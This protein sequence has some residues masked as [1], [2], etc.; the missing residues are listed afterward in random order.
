M[1]E[2]IILSV[3]D[4]LAKGMGFELPKT[5]KDARPEIYNSLHV[6]LLSF[7]VYYANLYEKG[8]VVSLKKCVEQWG[9][10]NGGFDTFTEM[11]CSRIVRQV[12]YGQ[13]LSSSAI[14]KK[15]VKLKNGCCVSE[16]EELARRAGKERGKKRALVLE[17][18]IKLATSMKFA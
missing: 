14:P 2:N 8:E 10:V 18:I 15:N 13:V 1:R 6:G 17:E 9:K 11:H 16:L 4:T 5:I 12:F 7:L 3:L